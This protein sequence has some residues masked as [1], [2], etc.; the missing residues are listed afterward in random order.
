[1]SGNSPMPSL[2][3]GSS[4]TAGRL[5]H[6]LLQP[7]G[8]PRIGFVSE[9]DA[10]SSGFVS[11]E[12]AP[13]SGFVS[14][15]DAPSSGF[16]SEEDA[17]SSG[18]VSEE[19][20]PSSGFVSEEDAPSSG[21]VSEEDAPSS[22]FVSEEDAPS[23]ARRP[24]CRGRW[25]GAAPALCGPGSGHRSSASR[26][27][28]LQCR[29]RILLSHRVRLRLKVPTGSESHGPR[30]P[31]AGPASTGRGPGGHCALGAAA[32][33]VAGQKPAMTRSGTAFSSRPVATGASSWGPECV[34][35]PWAAPEL[36]SVLDPSDIR[37]ADLCARPVG[38]TAGARVTPAT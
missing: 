22:G 2:G 31:A 34:P 19:D 15:E 21:F 17:P 29:T 6:T 9:E 13:S 35:S 30:P 3:L 28:G 24:P 25:T 10:P 11:E 27:Q 18:F 33:P 23:P 32:F 7:S 16:V 5:L 1:M 4:P 36:L 37:T 26:A 8:C 38:V 14:E 20:A 12:D